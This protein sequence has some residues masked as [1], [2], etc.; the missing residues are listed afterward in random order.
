MDSS[1]L[2]A[3]AKELGKLDDA[4]GSNA[5]YE[6]HRCPWPDTP[7]AYCEAWAKLGDI[8]IIAARFAAAAL[9]AL[10]QE[11]KHDHWTV[12]KGMV[13]CQ[14]A[15][16]LSVCKFCAALAQ[17]ETLADAVGIGKGETG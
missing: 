10:E 15:P 9:G 7:C 12:Q 3:L 17:A 6:T 1:R 5:Q 8:R 14:E 11:C 4:A 16:C 13:T 2:A